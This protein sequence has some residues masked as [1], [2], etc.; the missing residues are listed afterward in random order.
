MSPEV[1]FPTLEAETNLNVNCNE[2]SPNVVEIID[3]GFLP[4]PFDLG[5][6]CHL[7]VVGSDV[8]PM[9]MSDP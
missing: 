8:K 6:S 3:H 4:D 2:C 9:P 5:I 7:K 1:S